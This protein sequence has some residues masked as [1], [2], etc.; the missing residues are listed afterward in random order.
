MIVSYKWLCR[1]LP[2][3]SEMTPE[4]LASLLTM[5]GLEVESVTSFGDRFKGLVV[6]E[7]V[8]K[9]KHPD[10]DKLSVCQVSV[11]SE[12]FQVVCGA[13][14]VVAG[15]RYPLATLG[16][17]MPDGLVIKPV[18]LRGLASSGMLCS[19]K[20]LGL[21]AESDGLY[22]L[23]KN[24]QAGQS[25]AE[26]LGMN[27]VIFELGITPNRG[28]ALSHWG[29]VRDLAALTKLKPNYAF[30][31]DD[32]SGAITWGE[33]P[34][35]VQVKIET[36]NKCARFTASE[37]RGLKITASPAWLAGRMQVLGLRS[38][39]NVVDATNYVMLLT[40]H[41]VHAYDA[42]FVADRVLKVTEANSNLNYK[43]LDDQDR[44]LTT[45][46]LLIEDAKG[47]VGL[48]GIMGGLNSEI[49]DDTTD[50]ILEVAQ[51]SAEQVRKT[52][53]RLGIKT[54]SS[55]RFE[56][57]VNP[58]SVLEAH[59]ILQTL[60][61]H[62]AGGEPTQIVDQYPHQ[63]I[64]TKIEFPLGQIKRLLGYELDAQTVATYLRGLECDVTEQGD[65]LHVT[66]PGHRSDLTR[67]VDLVEEI[68]RL[69][70]LENVPIE[71]PRLPCKRPTES[72]L[73]RSEMDFIQHFVER[74]FVQT[75]HYSFTETQLLRQVLRD[76]ETQW[77]QL[78]N[79]LSE[80]LA[81]MR[82][83]L[84]PQL[85]M[86]YKK[87]HLQSE[88]GL[89]FVELRSVFRKI[90][91]KVCETPMLVG[92]YS[93]EPY[94]R[95][96]FGLRR[97]FDLFDGKGWLEGLFAKGKVNTSIEACE[98]WPYHPGQSVT[99][100]TDQGALAHVG[101]IHPEL[102]QA[103]KI[104]KPVFVFEIQ[105]QLLADFWKKD[106]PR[107]QALSSQP[108]VFRDLSLVAPVELSVQDLFQEIDRLKPKELKDI[109]LFDVF[110]GGSSLP[111]G[112]KS[113][114]FSIS[115]EDSERSLTD[116]QVNQ[117][118]FALV[119]KLGQKL[120]LELR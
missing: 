112:K 117:L 80:D 3:L 87:N 40:G 61:V 95:N 66:V 74:G 111:E 78:K 49:R 79:P 4:T 37:V 30:L 70:G 39:N 114:S 72:S 29:V 116:E 120:G 110:S 109:R 64:K 20:E 48:A 102:A 71:A 56:R 106:L 83:S 21:Q 91:N 51:F 50:V 27:D 101:L 26:A 107:Y 17:T 96:R 23:S 115:Y 104:K 63:L 89:K 99:Y 94:G 113:L 84:L 33:A 68:A 35:S 88:A 77:I 10:A 41:P 69:H 36:Q 19:A 86:T 103:L 6:G 9:E 2:G 1:L 8:Q 11:G 42:R 75:I 16:T 55:F 93:G 38:I 92:L 60:I 100:K 73:G 105:A 13:P 34:C 62:L 52:A 98:T 44:A 81:V 53:K 82:P 22:T 97:S 7:V 18:K 5:A 58:D 118:H 57:F 14:N 47:P 65:V 108:A 15:G 85:L 54:D 67:A 46:D 76:D 32:F 43:T 31:A 12:Q 45:G 119:E 28:D 90:G 24:A 59:R 25:I